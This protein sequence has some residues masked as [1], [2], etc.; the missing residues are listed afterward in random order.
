MIYDVAVYGATGYTGRLVV[1]D[2]VGRGFT[3]VI[4]GRSLSRL[5]ALA[6]RYEGRVGIHVT[7]RDDKPRLRELCDKA[8]VVIN[9]AV[10]YALTGVDLAEAAIDTGT[11]Y[12]D[13]S[14]SQRIT[15]HYI[16]TLGPRAAAAGVALLPAVGFFGSLGDAMVAVASSGLGSVDVDFGY[17]ITDW[18]PSGMNLDNVL[19]AIQREIVQYNRG[20]EFH[21]AMP[22]TRRV[23]FGAPLGVVRTMAFPAPDVFTIPRHVTLRSLRTSLAT[24]ALVSDPLGVTIPG[25]AAATRFGLR[26]NVTRAATQRMFA[27]VAKGGTQRIMRDDS[28]FRIVAHVDGDHGSR[29]L[30]AHGTAIYDLTAPIV[31]HLTA[32]VLASG[33]AG[34]G[35]LAASLVCDPQGLLDALSGPSF[36]CAVSGTESAGG[37]AQMTSSRMS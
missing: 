15:R 7:E 37:A 12:L 36:G 5:E 27:K 10:S 4:A 18:N 26:H 1:E 30:T 14:N 2:L 32:A 21:A 35:A 11:H 6:E 34:S 3:V 17:A 19:E 24:T 8:R 23:D 22:A 9:V 33:F 20:F 29:V 28:A 16:D 31:G 13:L 25:I